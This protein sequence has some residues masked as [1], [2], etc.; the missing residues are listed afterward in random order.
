MAKP[1]NKRKPVL[2]NEKELDVAPEHDALAMGGMSS[3]VVILMNCTMRFYFDLWKMALEPMSYVP[4][5]P[6][7]EAEN[8]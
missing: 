6:R 3:P 1:S 4:Q 2:S 8:T 7:L 5:W